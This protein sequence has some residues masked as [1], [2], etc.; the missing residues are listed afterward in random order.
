MPAHPSIWHSSERVPNSDGVFA[1]THRATSLGILLAITAI[2]CEG[3]AVATVLPSVAFDLGGLDNYGWAFSIFMLASLVGAISAGQ[4]TDRGNAM[5]PARL[6]FLCFSLGLV[7]AGLAPLWPIL[8]VGRL[9]Q[10]FGAGCLMAVA[11]VTIARGYVEAL[12]P[13]MLAL[14]SSAWIVPSLVGPA[15]AGQVAE[16]ASWRLVFLAILPPVGIAA[17]MLLPALRRLFSDADSSSVP[18]PDQHLLN[19]RLLTALRLTAGVALVLFAV[20]LPVLPIALVVGVVGVLLAVPALAALLP[21]GTLSAQAGLPAAVALRGLL[22]FGFFGC[23]ALIPLGLTTQRSVPASLVGLALTAGALAWV[24]G[25]WIQDRAEAKASSSMSARAMRATAGLFL[26]AAGIVGVAMVVIMPTLPIELVAVAWAVGGLGMGIA[27]PA[28]TLTALGVASAGEEGSA[29]ASLQVAETI[30]TAVG[31]GAAGA[32]FAVSVH[33]ERSTADGLTWAFLLTFTSILLA[34]VPA[35][36]M[37]PAG[38]RLIQRW[39]PK[40]VVTTRSS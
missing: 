35:V 22:A 5:L 12:R 27:Y 21:D 36:R 14:V 11:F 18:A 3:M 24:L 26:I 33:L 19:G 23:E 8:L 20:D 39:R 6:G 25:S 2:A 37:A 10:G 32:L 7:I 13:R 40:S 30:G 38:L 15:L 31:T 4:S 34:V 9:V 1:P 17:W 16:H 28:T 29:A